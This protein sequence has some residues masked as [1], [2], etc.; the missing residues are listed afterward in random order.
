MS[1]AYDQVKHVHSYSCMV[2]TCGGHFE[3]LPLQY[4]GLQ[5]AL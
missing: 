1:E 3:G 2:L 5:L 4:G